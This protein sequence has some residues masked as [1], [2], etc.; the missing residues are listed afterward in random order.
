MVLI[1]GARTN[2][3]VQKHNMRDQEVHNDTFLLPGPKPQLR[4]EED[5]S[6]LLEMWPQGAPLQDG[7]GPGKPQHT[8]NAEATDQS[9]GKDLRKDF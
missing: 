6:G 9:G 5:H 1:F 3:I 7:R 8:K 2:N 4:L